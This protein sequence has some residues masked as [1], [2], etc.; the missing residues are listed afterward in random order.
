MNAWRAEFEG[1]LELLVRECH[2]LVTPS[3]LAY[4]P[5]SFLLAYHG[6]NDAPL[7][8]KLAA[9]YLALC[10]ALDFRAPHLETPRAPE[11]PL[12]IGF[13]SVNTHDHSVSRCF[14]SLIARLA[15]EAR[16]EVMLVST[17]DP[18]RSPANPYR[19]FSGRFVHVPRQ[20]LAAREAIAALRLD[21]LVYQDIGMDELSYF[22]AFGRLARIQ[23]VLGGHPVTTGIPNI[24]CFIS[25]ALAEP[26]DAQQHYTERLLTV[27]R[28]PTLFEHPAVPQPL[29]SRTELGL[30]ESG[31]I[32]LCPMMLQKIHPDFDA[33]I[34]GI[35]ERDPTGHVVLFKHYSAR[36]EEPLMAR[37]ERS[38]APE[39]RSR[40][41]FLPW[42]HDYADF[43]NVNA[44]ADVVLDP[45]HFGI[46]STV[47][48]TFAVGT[49]IITRPGSYLRGRVGFALCTLLELP[50]CVAES[51]ED[52]VTRAVA[53]ATDAALLQ[54]L[55][56]R[57]LGNKGRLYD[58]ERAVDD[59]AG[60]LARLAAQLDCVPE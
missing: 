34:Q 12:R 4:S 57:I 3:R 33:A 47:I 5:S 1:Q 60:L 38:I 37:F 15:T 43:V 35:L 41:C 39:P 29:K 13:F 55:R 54:R 16:F 2:A 30:P 27:P 53:I 18:A 22:L 8:R 45:F 19:D 9:M 46:G 21:L 59:L 17:Q 11:A 49:P 14:A 20:Y 31:S 50:E 25:S 26:A 58:D 51:T 36:W 32:Y 40:I 44:L 28:F 7:M 23:C 42:I 48:A 56:E 52:Y 6:E 24:D 10:P